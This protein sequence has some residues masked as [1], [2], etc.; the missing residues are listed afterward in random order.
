MPSSGEH[1]IPQ[2]GSALTSAYVATAFVNAMPT[3]GPAASTITHHA[4]EARSSRHSLITSQPAALRE[5]KEH[6][7]Q[8]ST[9]ADAARA[10]GQLVDGALAAHASAA[11]QHE[12]IAHAGGVFDLMDGQHERPS[13]GGASPQRGANIARLTQVEAVEGLV[14][15]EDRLRCKEPDRQDGPLSLPF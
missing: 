14:R 8:V 11:Q 3:I 9:C 2:P 6:L 1:T 10:R 5:R 13:D 15:N 4:R 12:P 7:G